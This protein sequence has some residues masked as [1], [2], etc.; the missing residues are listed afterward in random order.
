LN[1]QNIANFDGV[2]FFC[3]NGRIGLRLNISQCECTEDADDELFDH[4]FFG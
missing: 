1:D 3:L 2:R 4:G